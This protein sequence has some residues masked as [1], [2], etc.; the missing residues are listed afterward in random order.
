MRK[1][2]LTYGI[3]AQAVQ[4]KRDGLCDAGI[5]A[6]LGVH[7]STFY[8]WLKEG[9]EAKTGVKRAL[10]EE[11]KRPNPNTSGLFLPLSSPRR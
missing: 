10:C 6:A 5:I 2:K 1:T 9:E 8:P 7:P 11:L 3:V 4:L